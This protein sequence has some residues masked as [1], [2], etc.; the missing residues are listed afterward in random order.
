MR[1]TVGGDTLKVSIRVSYSIAAADALKVGDKLVTVNGVGDICRCERV[2]SGRE[3]GYAAED[4]FI[5]ILNHP[6][7]PL[8]P[9]REG[10]GGSMG[11]CAVDEQ[12]LIAGNGGRNHVVAGGRRG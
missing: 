10:A 12:D 2:V 9:H 6:L 7:L 5:A 11:G 1:P 8:N 4:T 3:R